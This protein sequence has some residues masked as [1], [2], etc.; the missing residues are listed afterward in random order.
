MNNREL[1]ASTIGRHVEPRI[2][3]SKCRSQESRNRSNGETA[4]ISS[5]NLKLKNTLRQKLPKVKSFFSNINNRRVNKETSNGSTSK[6]TSLLK[7]PP[8]V[9]IPDE[10]ENSAAIPFSHIFVDDSDEGMNDSNKGSTSSIN[11]FD[12]LSL[13]KMK[14]LKHSSTLPPMSEHQKKS[15][16][17]DMKKSKY[18]GV[19]NNKSK[20]EELNIK[21][22]PSKLESV[23]EDEN[24]PN[25]VFEVL[26]QS[27]QLRKNT[28]DQENKSAPP[29]TSNSNKKSQFYFGDYDEDDDETKLDGT[30]NVER[31]TGYQPSSL[32]S[33]GSS[34]NFFQTGTF[35]RADQCL[36]SS[37]SKGLKNC[38]KSTLNRI[39]EK[40]KRLK[41]QDSFESSVSGEIFKTDV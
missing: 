9:T 4:S 2:Q 24:R 13:A 19:H 6:A 17:R 5:S 28:A 16:L 23:L 20:H 37:N 21:R 10:Y 11:T 33:S 38:R 22:N 35:H 34:I 41:H 25:A 27:I 40:F 39:C 26:N 3:Y 36:N 12:G 8:S 14:G 1:A 31:F 30:G 15:F 32:K 7:S 18:A 29:D